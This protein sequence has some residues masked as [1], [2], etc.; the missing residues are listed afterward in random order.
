MTASGAMAVGGEGGLEVWTGVENGVAKEVWMGVWVEKWVEA[1]VELGWSGRCCGSEVGGRVGG[2]VSME[3]HVE[4]KG[5]V[6]LTWVYLTFHFGG[7]S[8]PP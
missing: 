8:L 5:E 4:V 7:S 3:G 2:R 1:G 6:Y